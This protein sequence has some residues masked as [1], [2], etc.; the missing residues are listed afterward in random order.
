M[1]AAYET[2]VLGALVDAVWGGWEVD[3]RQADVE[4]DWCGD[5]KCVWTDVFDDPWLCAR[6]DGHIL[7]ITPRTECRVTLTATDAGEDGPTWR[8]G[9]IT[10][11]SEQELFAH[12]IV[13][14]RRSDGTYYA[15][16]YG[17][18]T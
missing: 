17:A 2:V 6:C 5:A 13:V 11:A 4:C 3:L 18:D 10:C 8:F 1:T 9:G 12:G 7:R 16:S 15:I 14:E